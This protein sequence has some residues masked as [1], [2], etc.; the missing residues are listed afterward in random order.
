MDDLTLLIFGVFVTL[1]LLAGFI[2]TAIEF[3]KMGE[4]PSDYKSAD[5]YKD[6]NKD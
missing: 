1:L 3:K 4:N 5:A 6:R 2:Y